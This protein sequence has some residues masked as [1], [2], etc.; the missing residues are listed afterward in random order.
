MLHSALKVKANQNLFKSFK[1]D[2]GMSSAKHLNEF[3]DKH[4]L[5]HEL[6]RTISLLCLCQN[7]RKAFLYFPGY[8]CFHDQLHYLYVKLSFLLAVGGKKS[9]E[10][11][12]WIQDSIAHLHLQKLG[13]TVGDLIC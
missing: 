13:I 5:S 8:M 1:P 11:L 9:W 7:C 3:N 6:P 12:L 10:C 4:G 2:R